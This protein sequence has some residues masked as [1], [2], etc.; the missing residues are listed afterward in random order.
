MDGGGGD[1]STIVRCLS[2]V[3]SLFAMLSLTSC[4]GTGHQDK[5]IAREAQ[6]ESFEIREKELEAKFRRMCFSRS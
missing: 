4:A 5:E 6:A 2:L 3:V 1:M